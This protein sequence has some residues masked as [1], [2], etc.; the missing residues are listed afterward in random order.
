M[1]DAQ[2]MNQS[3][4][5][6]C[7]FISEGKM[8]VTSKKKNKCGAFV[9]ILLAVMLTTA[10]KTKESGDSS[11]TMP[12]ASSAEIAT[13]PVTA[14]PTPKPATPTPRIMGVNLDAVRFSGR[15]LRDDDFYAGE[16]ASNSLEYEFS[17]VY[18]DADADELCAFWM[19]KYEPDHSPYPYLDGKPALE[20]KLYSSDGR[21]DETN[22]E[23]ARMLENLG[24]VYYG[25]VINPDNNTT[26]GWLIIATI[27]K[28]EELF[29]G[30][31]H[32]TPYGHWYWG[33][34]AASREDFEQDSI[35][36]V[37]LH[38]EK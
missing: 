26:K 8:R 13:I 2:T 17:S 6:P 35:I 29:A 38:L 12:P 21:M 32:D 18:A 19:A 37:L 9:L 27:P 36:N 1:R 16:I 34:Y 10:C 25:N 7:F 30:E 3:A 20:D 23:F 24:V 28:I 31:N 33:I 14:T 11:V 15:G 5:I 4:G 22:I